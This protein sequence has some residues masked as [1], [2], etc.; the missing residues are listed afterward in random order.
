MFGSVSNIC[1]LLLF[2]C[3]VIL[4]NA[5]WIHFYLWQWWITIWNDRGPK[6]HQT[7]Y[8]V[9]LH[10]MNDFQSHPH[11]EERSLVIL[12]WYQI[13]LGISKYPKP[14]N[15][16]WY[17]TWKSGIKPS[18]YITALLLVSWNTVQS[19]ALGWTT[20]QLISL[21]FVFDLDLNLL[22]TISNCRRSL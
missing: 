15:Q 6:L 20:Y 8:N 16:Y 13:V 19:K 14:R 1:S 18:P 3:I 7:L 11:S 2:D 12:H 10:M 17:L 5:V 22:K 21:M 4:T 9:A